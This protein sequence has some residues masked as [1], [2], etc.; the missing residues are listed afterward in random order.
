MVALV[1]ANSAMAQTMLPTYSAEA[2][3]GA[4][5]TT[6]FG[7]ST[8]A[9][10][11]ATMVADA[12]NQ[13]L[14]SSEGANTIYV[15]A[16]AAGMAFIEGDEPVL[17][18]QQGA[19]DATT[20]AVT[21]TA[22]AGT[23]GARRDANGSAYRWSISNDDDRAS[24]AM[25]RFVVTVA[26]DNNDATAEVN[27]SAMGTGAVAISVHSSEQG[28][29]FGTDA[30][31]SAS[32]PMLHVASSVDVKAAGA[33]E[34]HTAS[35]AAQF[36]QFV[37]DEGPGPYSLGGFNVTVVEGHLNAMGSTLREAAVA[38]SGEADPADATDGAPLT[39]AQM[40]QLYVAAGINAAMSSSRFHGADG[41]GF[42]YASGFALNSAADCSGHGPGGADSMATGI[43]SYP[44]ME[45]EEG[46]DAP[47]ANVVMAGIKPAPWY[48]CITIA[49][50][51][52][53]TIPEGDILMD[54]SLV[55]AGMDVRVA[56]PAASSETDIKVASIEHDG[57]TVQI[58]Y[59][60]TYENYN[61]RLVINNRSK[62]DAYF[63]VE[64]QTEAENADGDAIMVTS[65]NPTGMMTAAG[66]QT[67]VLRMMDLVTIENATRAAA[68]V[69]VQAGP[70]TV[71]VATTIVNKGTGATDTIV[72][73]KN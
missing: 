50:D 69:V 39:S 59:V 37:P 44:G 38:A 64:F 36:R 67:T 22:A 4:A 42:A 65:D 13:F 66:G 16:S 35:A 17:T 28:A 24:A 25:L 30:T 70:A 3:S 45:V 62:V 7:V 61:Q 12:T 57:T 32:A 56:S 49:D 58:P 73:D 31:Q 54:I 40:D 18:L 19:V 68:T 71:D 9:A 43:T 6:M 34:E 51:N 27:V 53:E 29:H 8:D 60:T 5:G 63:T 2:L 33:V 14:L 15:R 26:T 20:G 11:T 23:L 21:W 48:L 1:G 72:L 47:D 46:E 10:L 52:E 55:A 41:Q